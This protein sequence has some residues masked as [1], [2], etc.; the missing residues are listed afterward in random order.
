MRVPRHQGRDSHD[1]CS[2]QLQH[3]PSSSSH[4]VEYTH[5]GTSY[6]L[7]LFATLDESH[8]VCDVLASEQWAQGACEHRGAGEMRLPL[9]T[10]KL[11]GVAK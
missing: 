1:E 4:Q 2:N 3:T 7:G 8:R 6:T 10:R 9:M 5:Q 11:Q